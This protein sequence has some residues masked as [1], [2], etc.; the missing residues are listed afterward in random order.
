MPRRFILVLLLLLAPAARAVIVRGRVTDSLGRPLPG[1]RVQLISLA[2]GPRNAAEGIA[3]VDGSYELRTDLAG[4]FLLL[5]SPSLNAHLFAPQIGNPFYGGRTDILT[6]DISLDTAV[7]TPQTS[8]QT[9]LV[10]TPLLELSAPPVQIDADRLLMEAIVV[11]D[12]RSEPGTFVVQ[13]GQTGTPAQLYLR[14]APV[15]KTVIDGVSAEQLGGPF[16]LSP[17]TSSGLSA[18]ASTRAIELAP[19]ANPLYAVDAQSGCAVPRYTFRRNAASRAR[20]LGR[21]GQSLDHAQ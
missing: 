10:E 7:I 16:N 17:V 5:T 12:L 14:G 18:I 19:D 4:R 6:R 1:S 3:G 21:C 2:G 15:D 8:T 13:L 11:P 9:A 20:L